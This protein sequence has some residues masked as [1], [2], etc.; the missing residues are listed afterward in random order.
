MREPRKARNLFRELCV[1]VNPA[2]L[3]AE[4]ARKEFG[5]LPEPKAA[6]RAQLPAKDRNL[7]GLLRDYENAGAFLEGWGVLCRDDISDAVMLEGLAIYERNRRLDDF[8][9]LACK[10]PEVSDTV[11]KK[12]MACCEKQAMPSL[13]A[14]IL[15][16]KDSSK[17]V[18]AEG[19][20]ALMRLVDLFEKNGSGSALVLLLKEPGLPVA[21]QERAEVLLI[22]NMRHSGESGATDWLAY[23]VTMQELPKNVRETAEEALLVAVDVCKERGRARQIGDLMFMYQM[24]DRVCIKVIGLVRGWGGGLEKIALL[25]GMDWISPAVKKAAMD[26]ISGKT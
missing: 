17:E 21:V 14:K 15:N 4:L 3:G 25:S 9:D 26:T 16:R 1:P 12:A 18:K 24:P 7:I 6:S 23:I 10:K 2:S 22:K 13:I 5:P 8:C 11:L 19:E 20:N